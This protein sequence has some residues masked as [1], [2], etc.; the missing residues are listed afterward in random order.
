[1]VGRNVIIDVSKDGFLRFG[2][3]VRED[4]LSKRAAVSHNK[5]QKTKE[6]AFYDLTLERC[7][8]P[9]Q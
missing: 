2:A 3:F 1:M 8:S 6:A 9:T 4:K 7:W 5:T